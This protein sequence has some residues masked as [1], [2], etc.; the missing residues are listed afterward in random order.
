MLLIQMLLNN[1]T[2]KEGFMQL[3]ASLIIMFIPAVIAVLVTVLRE[4]KEQ[5]N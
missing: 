4:K 1:I 3:G 2:Y 5:V